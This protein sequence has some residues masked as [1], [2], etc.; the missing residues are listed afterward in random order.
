MSIPLSDEPETKQNEQMDICNK[1]KEQ[2]KKQFSVSKPILKR[3]TAQTWSMPNNTEDMTASLLLE[4]TNI[5]QPDS[6]KETKETNETN[7]TNETNETKE[8][9]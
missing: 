7:K 3:Q 9:K 2:P 6:I 8:T 1:I 4:M 5:H